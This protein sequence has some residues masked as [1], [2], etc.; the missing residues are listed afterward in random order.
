[1]IERVISYSIKEDWD[2]KKAIILLGPRQVGKTT[3]IEE[4]VKN[5][6]TLWLNGDDI[7]TR[8]NL[9]NSNATF[10]FQL[11]S[12][13]DVIVIDEAQRIS[14]IG[15]SLKILIDAK[16]NKQIII[17]GS[18]S[19]DL[20]N[21]I[22][23]SLTGRKW[24]HLLFPLSWNEL[25]NHYSFAKTITKLE[26]YLIYGMYPEVVTSETKKQK[27][28]LQL[29]GSYL[30]QDILE[31]GNIKKPDILVKLLNALALQMGNEISYNELSK[32]LGIDR[33]TVIN[34]IDLLEKTFIVF[35]LHPFS[36]NQRNE[37]TSKPKIY[38]Y[39]NGIRNAIIGQFS[40]LNNR[41]DIGALFENF[42]ISERIK[43]LKYEN[44]YGKFYYWRNTQQAEIDF[45]EVIENEI[46]IYEVKYNPNKK[47]KF[48]KS[49]TENYH[50]KEEIVINS[51]NFWQ[52][53]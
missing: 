12:D 10:L 46:K 4:L 38:F 50:P 42:I 7:Q 3:L 23:E 22:N 37:I 34:Y 33:L 16:L 24:E 26:E 29:A 19:L 51:E 53:L 11:V 9:S 49:F 30:Y 44:F 18:S 17:T 25:K 20:G 8:N 35:R 36:R 43:K 31:L 45:V 47:V 27:T 14:N 40:P 28:L 5:H 32:I 13:F 48:S 2:N 39:D 21:K 41:Q 52:Y 1:M 15:L 6:K